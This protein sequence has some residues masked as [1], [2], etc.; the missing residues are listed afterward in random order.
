MFI[1]TK[2]HNLTKL[3]RSGMIGQ[4]HQILPWSPNDSVQKTDQQEETEITEKF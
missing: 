4:H 3:Q 2:A 1:E